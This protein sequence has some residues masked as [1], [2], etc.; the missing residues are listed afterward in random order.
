MYET[1]PGLYISIKNTTVIEA[2]GDIDLVD[3]P[4]GGGGDGAG[5]VVL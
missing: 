1:K 5:I 2:S 4:G 3:E